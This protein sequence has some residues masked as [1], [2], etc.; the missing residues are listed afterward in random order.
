MSTKAKRR[1]WLR[2]S[3]VMRERGR[4]A[5]VVVCALVVLVLAIAVIVYILRGELAEDTQPNRAQVLSALLATA[6]DCASRLVGCGGT[7]VA[8][9]REPQRVHRSMRL[10]TSWLCKPCRPGQN[11][12]CSVEYRRPRPCGC[13]GGGR[14]RMWLCRWRSWQPLLR[15]Q[16]TPT[17][18]CRRLTSPRQ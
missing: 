10:P 1:T 16:R 18:S 2:Y 4:T 5:V 12:S 13:V 3:H 9:S 14:P 7:V 15:W 17:Q 8:P 11:R 6:S